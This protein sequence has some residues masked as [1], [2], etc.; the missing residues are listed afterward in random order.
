MGARLTLFVSPFPPF[1]SFPSASPSFPP[2][3]A[4]EGNGLK[5]VFHFA[6]DPASSPQCTVITADITNESPLPM[7]DFVFQAAV[8]KVRWCG[9]AQAWGKEAGRHARRHAHW[10]TG[11]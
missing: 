11:G 7:T 6:K 4:F 9:G 1:V 3:T 10:H 2:L 8:P 5:V